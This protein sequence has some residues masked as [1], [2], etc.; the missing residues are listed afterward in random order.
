[1]CINI[2]IFNSE[3]RRREGDEGIKIKVK[4]KV[5]KG[6]IVIAEVFRS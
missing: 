5:S 2:H 4:C 3:K 6:T 1:M